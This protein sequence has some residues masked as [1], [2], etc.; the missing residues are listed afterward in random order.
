MV[1]ALG[2]C[3]SISQEQLRR[4]HAPHVYVIGDSRKPGRIIDAIGDGYRIG[5]MI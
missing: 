1:L 2:A 5:Q 4:I 3:P